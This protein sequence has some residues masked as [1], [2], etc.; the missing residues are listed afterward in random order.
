MI[1]LNNQE[2]QNNFGGANYITK[3]YAGE[4]LV[5]GQDEPQIVYSTATGNLTESNIS[6]KK[7]QGNMTPSGS[8]TISSTNTIYKYSML[9]GNY[10]GIVHLHSDNTISFTG[11]NN[12]SKVEVKLV[13]HPTASINQS[14]YYGT[15]VNKGEITHNVEEKYSLWT[16]DG[17]T[18][19]ITY[20]NP[21][22]TAASR[23]YVTG[24]YR[25]EIT[26][27]YTD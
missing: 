10:N 18:G 15:S 25:Y 5:L 24:V 16:F 13:W 26:V 17:P 7:V 3:V 9:G 19:V 27:Y 11:I 20:N 22:M 8:V 14:P 21:N 12:I 4:N 1:C 2:I 23:M 6:T